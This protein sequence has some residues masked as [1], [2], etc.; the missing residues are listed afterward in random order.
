MLGA[1]RARAA[2]TSAADTWRKHAFV[3][4]SAVTGIKTCIADIL[5]QTQYE[6]KES[7][8]WRRNFV[9]SSFGLCYLGAFQYATDPPTARGSHPV[10]SRRARGRYVQYTL[11]F[12]RFL[13]GTGAAA[14]VKRVAFD[15][16]INT[17]LW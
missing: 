10:L 7:I 5:V 1:M 17:G 2:L 8:D 9:F 16:L 14:V 3:L 12:P 6:G 13:P 15:Q 11:W 4:G